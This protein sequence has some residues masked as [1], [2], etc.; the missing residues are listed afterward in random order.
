MTDKNVVTVISDE[1]EDAIIAADTAT[2]DSRARLREKIEEARDRSA[3]LAGNAAQKA[4]DFVHDHPV[5]TVAG[6]I[7]LGAIVA[8]A[9]SRRRSSGDQRGVTARAVQAVSDAASPVVKPATEN[10]ARLA[11]L[12]AELALAYAARAADKGKEGV[13]KLEEI[14][15]TV[16]GKLSEGGTEVRRRANDLAGTVLTHAT[17]FL[18]KLRR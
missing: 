3:E 17:E 5:A 18:G 16:G 2:A 12:G 7:V 14:G 4:R 9:L 8:G 15:G 11:A 10:I 6:G 13:D 1:V